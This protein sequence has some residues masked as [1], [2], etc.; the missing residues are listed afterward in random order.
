MHQRIPTLAGLTSVLAAL[1]GCSGSSSGVSVDVIFACDSNHRCGSGQ[2]CVNGTC[3]EAD[4][5]GDVAID[6]SP[7]DTTASDTADTALP[8]TAPDTADTAPDTS[9]AADVTVTCTPNAGVFGCP[10][11]TAG[12]CLS[13]LCIEGT[14]GHV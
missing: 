8:D 5:H 9:D 4:A 12:D 1:G 10:C 7:A 13:S 2:T 11:G 6:T 3:Q 14:G